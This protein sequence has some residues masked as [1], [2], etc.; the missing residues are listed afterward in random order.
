MAD[1]VSSQDHGLICNL[2]Y[3]Q[4]KFLTKIK[5]NSNC[6]ITVQDELSVG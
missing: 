5:E 3:E 6:I 1:R 2:S 4:V